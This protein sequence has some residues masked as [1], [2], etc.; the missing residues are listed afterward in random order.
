[1]AYEWKT[2]T[3]EICF[4]PQGR[5]L[6]TGGRPPLRTCKC[7]PGGGE[8]QVKT[9]PSRNQWD[10]DAGQARPTEPRREKPTATRLTADTPWTTPAVG[11][12]HRTEGSSH[13]PETTVSRGGR[14]SQDNLIR[15]LPPRRANLPEFTGAPHEDPHTFLEL[16]E[17]RLA[18]CHNH[19]SEWAE[20]ASEQM[21]GDA[22]A[23]WSMWGRFAMPWDEFA[24]EFIRRF[25]TGSPLVDCLAQFYGARQR[26]GEAVEPFIGNKL[27]LFRRITHGVEPTQAL[28]TITSLVKDELQPFLRNCHPTNVSEFVR[29]ALGH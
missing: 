20:R 26:E 18:Q 11:A 8:T 2:G 27:Q 13:A 22:R 12:G 7:A 29:E 15:D 16:C 4:W 24:D 23:W 28:P 14:T 17:E 6:L 19:Q 3:C 5:D 21:R 1:M 10:T 25:D 9:E